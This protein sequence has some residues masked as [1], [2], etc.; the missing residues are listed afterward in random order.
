MISRAL[1]E[2]NNAFSLMNLKQINEIQYIL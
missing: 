1:N 2:V